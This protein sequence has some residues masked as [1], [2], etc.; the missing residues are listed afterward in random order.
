M[1]KLIEG[2]VYGVEEAVNEVPGKGI[3]DA[4]SGSTV[5]GWSTCTALMMDRMSESDTSRMSCSTL[6]SCLL[7]VHLSCSKCCV[8][9]PTFH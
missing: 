1:V 5:T 2:D 3:V 4:V 9:D 6:S 7:V 8:V